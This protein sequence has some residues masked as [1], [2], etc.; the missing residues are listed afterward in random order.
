MSLQA[1][2]SA[3]FTRSATRPELTALPTLL[4]ERHL[5]AGLQHFV[6]QEPV[7]YP[8]SSLLCFS[9]GGSVKGKEER[10]G[11]DETAWSEA[12]RHARQTGASQTFLAKIQLITLIIHQFTVNY[13]IVEERAWR[14]HAYFNTGQAGVALQ[15]QRDCA[16][17]REVLD[18]FHLTHTQI[19][20]YSMKMI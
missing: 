10:D 8:R 11:A 17:T 1:T 15:R 12:G 19:S 20:N 13:I 16:C 3:V 9:L 7:T 5:L 2:H 18:I 6:I 14:E 4:T